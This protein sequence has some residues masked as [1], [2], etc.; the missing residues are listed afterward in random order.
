MAA[1]DSLTVPMSDIPIGSFEWEILGSQ[2][3]EPA[4]K[5]RLYRFREALYN[6]QENMN[7]FD[8]ERIETAVTDPKKSINSQM[9][10]GIAY[11]TAKADDRFWLSPE[12]K[13]LKMAGLSAFDV[14]RS[15]RAETSAHQVFFGLLHEGKG[16]DGKHIPVAIKPC[17]TK[18]MA[19]CEEG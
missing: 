13:W 2:E 16:Q 5:D 3:L 6:A 15:A 9:L 11:H 4:H 1:N 7:V 17:T 14:I 10:E 12:F 18:P 19:A 8:I